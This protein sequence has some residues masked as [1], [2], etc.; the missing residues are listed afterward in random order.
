[1]WEKNLSLELKK[2]MDFEERIFRNFCVKFSFTLS[3]KPEPNVR[4]FF[5]LKSFQKNVPTGG[6]QELSRERRQNGL[7]RVM[8][9]NVVKLFF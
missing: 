2:T 7:D 8:G 6:P 1:M 9:R 3:K 5:V 4:I